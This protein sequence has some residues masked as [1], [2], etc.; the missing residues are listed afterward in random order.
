MVARLHGENKERLDS[1][2]CGPGDI[3]VTGRLLGEE[4]GA[5]VFTAWWMHLESNTPS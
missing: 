2:P 1:E 3:V 5:L 4:C